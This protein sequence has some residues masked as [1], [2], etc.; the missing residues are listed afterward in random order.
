M[1]TLP[2]A[3]RLYLA[4]PIREALEHWVRC[5]T[6]EYR[7]VRRAQI[8]L[9]AAGGATNAAIARLLRLSEDTVRKWRDRFAANPVLESLDDL[10]RSGRP[11]TIPVWARCELMMLACSNREIACGH[12]VEDGKTPMAKYAPFHDVWTYAKLSEALESRTGY[13]LGRSEVGRILRAEKIRPHL[14][15]QWLHSPDPEFRPKVKRICDLYLSPPVGAHVICVDEKTSIQALERIHDARPTMPGRL[16]RREYEYVRHGTQVLIAGFDV[17]TG[18]V[19]GKCYAQRTGANLLD[20]MKQLARL[21]PHGDIYIVWDNLNT[22][23]ERSW[24]ELNARHGYRFHFVYTPKHASWVNQVELWFSVLQRRVIKHG[25]FESL[26]ALGE[27]IEA[28][29]AHWNEHEAHPFRWKF[30]GRF[31]EHRLPA[32]D[33]GGPAHAQVPRGAR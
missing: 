13:R 27:R 25:S 32:T 28:F 30:R 17:R 2:K 12:V 24:A 1:A 14:T 10:P 6:V 15:R 22:H 20:F 16:A 21:Y 26:R 11:G 7:L 3:T 5:L 8:V 23:D 29:I 31:T 19:V 4:P 33:E 18:R 9:L